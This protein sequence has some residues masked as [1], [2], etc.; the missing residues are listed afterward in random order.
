MRIQKSR[1]KALS[2]GEFAFMAH[3]AY[4]DRKAARR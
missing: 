4:L 2:P 3:A 1:Q